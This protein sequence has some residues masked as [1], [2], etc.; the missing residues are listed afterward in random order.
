MNRYIVDRCFHCLCISLTDIVK[1]IGCQLNAKWKYFG[2]HLHVDPAFMD[3]VN[4][5]NLGITGDCL[6]DLVNK[7]VGRHEETGGR[8]RTWQTV[9]EAVRDCGLEELA[10]ELAEKH[11]VTLTQQ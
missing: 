5:D 11:G 7:W 8:P 2:T 3:A 10:F 4:K 9:V 6:L 1:A